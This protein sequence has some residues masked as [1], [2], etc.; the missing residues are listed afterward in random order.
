MCTKQ[1]L[2]KEIICRE[3]INHCRVDDSAPPIPPFHHQPEKAI[4]VYEHALKKNPRDGALATKIGKALVK[5]HNYVKVC[6]NQ[7]HDSR[8]SWGEEGA[9]PCWLMWGR[10]PAGDQLLRSRPED[11]A[12]ELPAL[13]P[14][15]AADEDEAVR[16]LR[17]S[18][19]RSPGPR[20]RSATW[21][22]IKAGLVTM[23]LTR[24]SFVALLFPSEWNADAVR[25]LS[26]PGVAV[27]GP[28]QGGQTRGRF[29]LATKGELC[30]S[31]V[32][33]N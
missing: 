16:T 2:S 4:E 24:F 31:C 5:T 8:H 27:K 22:T 28:K 9:E 26:I 19:A 21:Q 20:T 25:W 33:L 30:E 11:G 10:G 12:A 3:K 14:G 6:F 23:V 15:G 1:N 7:N 32:L 13:R 17:E 29:A 18:P